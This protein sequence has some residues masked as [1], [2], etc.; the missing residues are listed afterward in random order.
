ME[1]SSSLPSRWLRWPEAACSIGEP[2]R[3]RTGVSGDHDSDDTTLS[4]PLR[5]RVENCA[6]GERLG[7]WLYVAVRRRHCRAVRLCARR[8]PCAFDATIVVVW[9]WQ[10]Q[11]QQQELVV[12]VSPPCLHL[13]RAQ[14]SCCSWSIPLSRK[15]SR[16]CWRGSA[17]AREKGVACPY[18]GF[19]YVI[20]PT[21]PCSRLVAIVS[22]RDA[23]ACELS[24]EIS[25]THT[26]A[27][28]NMCARWLT[29]HSS[30]SHACPRLDGGCLCIAAS[31]FGHDLAHSTR[32]ISHLTTQYAESST[33][34]THEPGHMH[35][36][37]LVFI[38]LIA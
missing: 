5:S 2:S 16:H 29:V 9:P 31:C 12:V 26:R 20:A 34:S 7:A 19:K 35:E 27:G 3:A 13:W 14:E 4:A 15:R 28:G 22:Y 6:A 11:Q 23:M 36:P 37:W 8:L 18:V 38:D 21:Y 10:Q 24:N 25:C 30:D 17:T 33:K 32:S 1:R